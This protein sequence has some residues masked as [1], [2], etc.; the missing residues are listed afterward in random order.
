MGGKFKS[1]ML[2]NSVTLLCISCTFQIF[3]ENSLIIQSRCQC[4]RCNDRHL[5]TCMEILECTGKYTYKEKDAACIV[6]HWDYLPMVHRTVLANVEQLLPR[7]DGTKYKRKKGTSKN[8]CVFLNYFQVQ[9]KCSYL[10]CIF[11]PLILTRDVCIAQS[12]FITSN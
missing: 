8:E 5:S 12:P 6:E 3:I 7:K 9:E 1:R 4:E 10:Y 11:S 2:W